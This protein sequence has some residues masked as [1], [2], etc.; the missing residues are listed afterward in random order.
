MEVGTV[1]GEYYHNLDDHQKVHAYFLPNIC[2]AFLLNIQIHLRNLIMS[3]SVVFLTAIILLIHAHIVYAH[4][5][6][7]Q[8]NQ[9]ALHYRIEI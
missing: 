2:Y 3:S 5:C 1:Y 8:I 9:L 7:R 6:K 4:L